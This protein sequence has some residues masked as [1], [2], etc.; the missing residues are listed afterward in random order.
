MSSEITQ[1]DPYDNRVINIKVS[2]YH[3]YTDI[4][5]VTELRVCEEGELGC[6]LYPEAFNNDKNL[7]SVPLK[8][9]GETINYTVPQEA[10]LAPQTLEYI[11]QTESDG[12][13]YI[14]IKC[15][16][17]SGVPLTAANTSLFVVYK[18]S[19]LNQYAP[20]HIFSNICLA[21]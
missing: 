3:Y 12:E 18:L 8:V 4:L 2:N 19:T 14:L 10:N 6:E 7:A 20:S 1:A 11:I 5:R 13:I 21:F 17:A 9:V 16:Q 15:Y